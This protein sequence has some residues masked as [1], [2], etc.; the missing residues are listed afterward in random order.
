MKVFIFAASLRKASI[1]KKLASLIARKL[2]ERGCEVDHET[3][4]H[5]FDMPM[6]DG[7][8]EDA[9]GLPAG[10]TALAD[11]I[12]AADALVIVTPEY[13]HSIPGSLKNA[14]DWLSRI[15]PYPTIGKTVMMASAA[16]PVVGGYRGM[17]ALQEPLALMGTWTAPGKF[18][19]ARAPQAFTEDDRLKDEAIEK[20]LDG[21]LD[22]FVRNGE[23]R[24]G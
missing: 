15:H 19:L 7:D 3:D 6:Y 22:D 21:M 13:N 16:T 24:V 4:F 1:N 5:V 18:G 14:I 20:L 11:R 17:M 23:A 2:S 9:E 10:C 8:L 12:N